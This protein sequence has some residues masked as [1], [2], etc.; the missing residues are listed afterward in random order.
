MVIKNDG[1]YFKETLILIFMQK[2]EFMSHASFLPRFYNFVTLGTLGMPDHQHQNNSIFLRN[3]GIYL[4][5]FLEILHFDE[6]SIWLAKGILT[7]N[8]RKRLVR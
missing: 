6:F 8:L 7:H 2:I 5:F 3:F 1:T 4:H